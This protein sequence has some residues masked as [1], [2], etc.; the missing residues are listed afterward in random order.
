V[1]QNIDDH[2]S[3]SSVGQAVTDANGEFRLENVLP[4]KYTVFIASENSGFRGDSVSFEV[5][6]RDVTDLLI[7]AASACSVS[8]LVVFEGVEQT[9]K[10]DMFRDLYINAWVESS[11]AQFDSR[12][13]VPVNRDGS[14]KVSGLSKGLSHFNFASPSGAAR[15]MALV[16]IERDG[17]S[18]PQGIT[19]N[20]GEQVN[21]VRLVVKYLTGAIHGQIKVEGDELLPISR[22]SVWISPV[23]DNRSSYQFN[24]ASSP[25]LDSRRR[26]VVEGLAVGTY[27]VNVA[28]FDPNRPDTSNIFKQ[29]VVVSDNAISEVTVVIKTKP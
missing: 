12:S 17:I 7:R 14:F 10:P 26:F 13:S 24:E 3:H 1:H 6:D 23:G 16:R 4:G 15:N 2:S 27:E 19:L 29:Q 5:V 21:G 28:V 18:Q 9:A 25:Q 20:D 11:E 22:M 8:G